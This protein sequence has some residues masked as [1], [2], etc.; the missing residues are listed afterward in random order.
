[1]TPLLPPVARVLL[2][3]VLW[4]AL[5]ACSGA[6][7]S[8]AQ[9]EISNARV[10]LPAGANGVAYLT[11]RNTGDSAD[12]LLSI[13]TDVAETVEL[14]ESIQQ[15]GAMS[16]EPVEGIEIPAGSAAVLEPGGLHAMLLNVEGDLA[17][18]DTVDLTLTFERSESQTVSADV[19]PLID[20]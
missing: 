12:R 1:M 6:A 15:N 13:D 14:H 9:I 3:A 4:T 11:V 10:P 7:A 17:Q 8:P 19:V 5:S 16:M 20:E 2:L 18:G